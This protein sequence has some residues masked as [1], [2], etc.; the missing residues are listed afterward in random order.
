MFMTKIKL[1]S[2]TSVS[3]GLQVS[4]KLWWFLISHRI[5]NTIFPFNYL[6]SDKT[7]WLVALVLLIKWQNFLACCTSTDSNTIQWT[8]IENDHDSSLSL[9]S[10]SNL[11]LLV[12]QFNNTTP[13]NSTDPQKNSSK[14]HNIEEMHDIEIP[15]KN[16]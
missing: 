4:S 5:F 10:S 16:C 8:D 15:H 9:K 12:N 11:E 13:E 7:S 3:F 14:Y 1:F 6:S 2:V